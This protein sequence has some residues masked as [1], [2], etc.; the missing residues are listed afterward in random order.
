[1]ITFDWNDVL[2]IPEDID[3]PV[4]YCTNSNKLGVFKDTKTY[5]WPE[6]DKLFSDWPR[7]SKKYGIKYWVYQKEL[8]KN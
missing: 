2:I 4:L 3:L 6:V 5:R 7:L 8:I 1:M